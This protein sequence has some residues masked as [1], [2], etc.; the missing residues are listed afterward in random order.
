M[1]AGL[2]RNG[3]DGLGDAVRLELNAMFREWETGKHA[4]FT[5]PAA[6]TPQKKRP[7]GTRGRTWRKKSP[8]ASP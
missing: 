7:G 1:R 6:P 4:T 3:L 2:P 5:R 8:K